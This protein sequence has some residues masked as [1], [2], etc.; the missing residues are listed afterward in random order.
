MT[1]LCNLC[2]LGTRQSLQAR[3]FERLVALNLTSGDLRLAVI[4]LLSDAVA[5]A[6]NAWFKNIA[7][8]A[9]QGARFASRVTAAD[10]MVAAG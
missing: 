4:T 10:T 1:S 3:A 7:T 2:A 9:I 6:V 5:A 8:R